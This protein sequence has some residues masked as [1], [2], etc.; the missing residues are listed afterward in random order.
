MFLYNVT[1]QQPSAINCAC[2]GNFSGTKQQEIIVARSSVLELISPNSATGKLNPQLALECFGIIRSMQPFRLTGSSKDYLVVGSDSGRIVILEYNPARNQF[3]KLHQETYGKSGCRRIVPGQFLAT[4]PKGRAVMIAAVEKQKLVYI[5]NRD[6]AA[7]LTISSP[8][9]AHKTA[10]I[11]HHI[12]GVD[13]GYENPIFAALEIDYSDSDQDPSGEAFENAEKMLTFYELDLG[14]NHVVRKWSEPVDPRANMLI[15]VPGGTDGPS[16]VL[17]C[18]ENYIT[19]RHQGAPAARVPIPRRPS[20]IQ[21]SE[22]GD[23]RGVIIVTAVVHKLKKDFFV[24]V[25]TEDGDIFKLTMDYETSSE[26]AVGPVTNLKIKYF[27]TIPASTSLCILKTG[28]LFNASEFGNH[29][30]YQ[31]ENLGDDDEE[32]MEYSSGDF[33]SEEDIAVPFTPRPLRNLQPVDEMESLSPLIDAQIHNLA[34]EESPQIYALCGRGAKS[35]FRI[36]RHGLE[37]N[38]MVASELPG[39][40]NAVWTVKTSARDEYDSYIVVSFVNETLVLSIGEVV[41]EVTD[42]GLLTSTTTLTVAQLGEDALVQI[43][44]HGI[45]HIRSDKRISVWEAPHNKIIVKAVCNQRQVVIGLS[46]GEIVYFELDASGQLNEY[47]DRKELAASITAL[48]LGPIPDG[49]IRTKFLS[50]GCSDN[51]V[52]VISLDPDS[53]LQMLSMQ[54]VSAM[55]ESLAI[56]HMQDT[57]TAAGTLYLNIGLQNGVLLRTTLDSVTGVLSDSRLRFLGT[58]PVR[59]F[60]IRLCGGDAVLAL[61]SRG[62]L[63]YVYQGRQCLTPLSYEALEFGS[64]LCSEQ[65]PEGVVAISANTLRVLTF[66]KL[67]SSFN[68]GI[69]PLKYTPRRFTLHQASKNFVIIESDYQTLCPSEKGEHMDQDDHELPPDQFGHLRGEAGKWASC[70]R[71]VN[72]FA[73]ETLS[74]V[75]LDHNESALSVISCTFHGNQ[76]TYIIVGTAKNLVLAPR[77]CS[78]AALRVYRVSHDGGELEFVHSTPVEDVP[79]A[80]CQFQGRLLAGIGKCLRI[81]DMGKRKLLRKCENKQFP[82]VIVSIQTQG[83]RIVVADVQESCHYAVYQHQDNRIMIFADDILPRFMTSMVMVDYETVI[84]GDKFGNIFANRLSASISEEIDDDTTGNKLAFEKGVLNGAPYKLDHLAEFFV[85]ETITSLTKTALVAGGREI[86]MY[87]TF[88]G[89]I[90][91]LVPFTSKEDIDFFQ[92]ME[93]TLRQHQPPFLGRDHLSY[94]S[95][96][97]PCR[98]VIDGDL[99]EKYLHTSQLTPDQK[100]SIAE[101][102]ERSVHEVAKKIEDMRT[103]VAF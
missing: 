98:A 50:V 13:V 44:P 79:Y 70:I 95:F 84:G 59:L 74:L 61:S 64:G 102:L 53:C 7:N 83:D 67:G 16:G 72:P 19:W 86:V 88:L 20:A 38:E 3:V 100:S 103:R 69:V 37:V 45:R 94:R 87:T 39:N 101:E 73:G 75:D 54:A 33:D 1:L 28:Y 93:M 47:Q 26:G 17:V 76:G 92:T 90:G 18:S 30:L 23:D 89:R 60:T 55:P 27:D 49:R 4:D 57:G 43:Y 6:S 56:A 34:G 11:T 9:E 52:R 12:V 41:D 62:W 65:C 15:A 80:L 25:Q 31:I 63:N 32:Q 14:L 71:L 82:N 29:Y 42:S 24:L 66:E 91:I 40:P 5:L 85:G 81:Y 2:I 96:F 10:T 97:Q 77:S 36:L 68:Q 8:L 21:S 51:T 78:E 58:R 99:C 35:S 46:G 22:A 48:T